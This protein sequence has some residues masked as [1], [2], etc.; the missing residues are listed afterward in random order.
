E[1][2]QALGLLDALIALRP[3]IERESIYGSAYK[4]L[5]LIEAIAG[6]S[7]QEL[8]AIEQ[9]R[10]HYR[11]AEDLAR[12]AEKAGRFSQPLF[13]PAMNRLAAQ[14]ALGEGPPL[15]AAAVKEIRDS[16]ASVAPDFW[17]VVGQTEIDLLA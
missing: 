4:R 3:T 16:M 15:D 17:S 1:I 5:A 2:T 11:K 9:M 8:A 13:Y 14:L 12:D 7:R 10:T 6:R